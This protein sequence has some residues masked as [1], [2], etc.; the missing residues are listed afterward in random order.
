MR[1]TVGE[2][3]SERKNINFWSSVGR[4]SNIDK[5]HRTFNTL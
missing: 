5:S 2:G 1:K 4:L 3:M